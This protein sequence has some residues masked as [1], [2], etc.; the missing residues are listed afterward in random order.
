[1][2]SPASATPSPSF[3]SPTP[4]RS[5]AAV[6]SASVGVPPP[7]SAGSNS[8]GGHTTTVQ[9]LTLVVALLAV[10][11]TILSARWL[12]K[13]G[14]ETSKAA[15]D[16][17][18]AA[19]KSAGAAETSADA[20][21]RS[22]KAAE[23]SVT[24]NAATAQAAGIRADADA[25]SKR[26]QEAASQLGHEKA[27][28][29]LAGV[30]AM[31]RLADDWPDERQTCVDVLCAYLRLPWLNP[32]PND[33]DFQVRAT[34]LST[35]DRHVKDGY[36]GQSWSGLRFDFSGA[37]I[38]N[39]LIQEGTFAGEAIFDEAKFVGFENFLSE[40]TFAGRVSFFRADV[41]GGL[42][43]AKIEVPGK[44]TMA[45]MKQSGDMGFLTMIFDEV[46]DELIQIDELHV[47]KKASLV[48][49]KQNERAWISMTNGRLSDGAALTVAGRP[50]TFL[51]DPAVAM[52]FPD[53]NLRGWTVGAGARVTTV[54]LRPEGNVQWEPAEVATDAE[55]TIN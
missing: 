21:Q 9:G 49:A 32:E 47:A 34:I 27:A 45:K 42:A 29:R 44:L 6:T 38:R 51:T 31:A 40:M 4:G 7:T 43:L 54:A 46:G 11:A 20:S 13:T 37:T 22:A 16:S 33:Q 50:L 5:Q 2:T 25:L 18:A 14:K 1:M 24:L 53:V 39:M 28:V 52:V 17:A 15:S 19:K 55:I 10:G 12:R 23:D 41:Q 3:S 48:V 36:T 30:Y 35:I 8:S 26:Y